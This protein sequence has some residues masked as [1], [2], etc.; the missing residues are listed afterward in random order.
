MIVSAKISEQK[1]AQ[2]NCMPDLQVDLN[3][4]S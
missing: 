3:K 2:K 4:T 1:S